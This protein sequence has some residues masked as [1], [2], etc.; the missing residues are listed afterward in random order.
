MCVVLCDTEKDVQGHLGKSACYPLTIHTME[1]KTSISL[2]V[3]NIP[4]CS[5]EIL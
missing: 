1:L 2:K 5:Q 4:L 3:V